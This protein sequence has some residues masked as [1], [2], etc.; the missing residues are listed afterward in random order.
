MQI[1]CYIAF[2]YRCSS[3]FFENNKARDT[4]METAILNTIRIGNVTVGLLG[5]DIALVQLV[6]RDITEDEAVEYLYEQ[7]SKKNYIPEQAIKPYKEALR[8]EYR[9]YNNLDSAESQGVTIRVLGRPC[10]VC[11]KLKLVLIDILQEKNI[12]A[13]IEDIQDL[14]EIWRYGVTKTPALIINGELKSAGIQPTRIQ[15]E[16][17]LEEAAK[18]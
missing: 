14:D 1:N 9:R 7:V 12:A 5:L 13:D 17:W 3:T 15:L 6:G 11:N 4:L 8:K 16:K 10:I 18:K 2:I